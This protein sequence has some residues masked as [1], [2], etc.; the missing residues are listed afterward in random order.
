M[1]PSMIQVYHLGGPGKIRCSNSPD[2]GPPIAQYYYLVG[3]PQ[4]AAHGFRIDTG[5][6]SLSC[7]DGTHIGRGVII[8]NGVSLLV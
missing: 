3:L 2:P 7:L 5:T 8:S 6:K 4:T 1:L